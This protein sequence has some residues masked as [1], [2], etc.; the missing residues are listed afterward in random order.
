MRKW[1]FS[2]LFLLF[3]PLTVL[4]ETSFTDASGRRLT[5]D[6]APKRVVSLYG[7]F[8]ETWLLAGGGLV[9]A[10]QDAVA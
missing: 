7:S 1:L 8:A 6:T 5:F 3:I 4:G 2:L 9:G 10:T